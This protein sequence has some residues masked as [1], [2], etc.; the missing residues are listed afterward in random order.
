MA[1]NKWKLF[2][3]SDKQL[4]LI[5]LKRP[6]L[7]MIIIVV[8]IALLGALYS[9]EMLSQ[10]ISSLIALSGNNILEGGLGLKNESQT[11]CDVTYSI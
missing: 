10:A 6:I 8:H 4:L 7:I 3:F 1:S 2:F 11:G 5:A 9:S